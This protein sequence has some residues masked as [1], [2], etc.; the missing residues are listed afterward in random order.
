MLTR[1]LLF[2]LIVASLISP[3]I[4]CSGLSANSSN[5]TS[6][7]GSP[8]APVY[9]TEQVIQIARDFSPDCR[10]KIPPVEGKG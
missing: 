3:F 4:A 8:L 6:P 5:A 1:K 2:I 7:A 9:T 10:K